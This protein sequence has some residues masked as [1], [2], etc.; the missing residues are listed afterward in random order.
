MK[1]FDWLNNINY[2]KE[3]V[4]TK[5]N[6]EEYKQF[7]FNQILA[8][9]IDCILYVN[10]INRM[11]IPDKL[12]YDYLRLSLSKKKRYSKSVKKDIIENI[13]YIKEYYNVNDIIAKEYLEILNEKQIMKIK[14]KLNKGG[15]L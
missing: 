2:I 5:N 9:N 10:D 7:P 6:T 1:F 14:E 15:K 4:M 3:D 13:E 8:G 11:D 12:H